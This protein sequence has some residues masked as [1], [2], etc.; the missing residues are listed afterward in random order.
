MRIPDLATKVIGEKRRWRQYKA[1]V[2]LLPPNYRGAAKG[3]ERY[4]MHAGGVSDGETAMRMLEDLADLFEQSAAN[5]SSVRDVVGEDPVEFV[6]A[7]I[8]NYDEGSWLRRERDRLV[9]AID[10]AEADEGQGSR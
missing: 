4:L 5:G 2:A 3:V 1:R 9:K 10:D 7:F 8:R 6:E